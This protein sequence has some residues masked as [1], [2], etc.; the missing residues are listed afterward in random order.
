MCS[1]CMW[2]LSNNINAAAVPELRAPGAV[3]NFNQALAQCDYDLEEWRATKVGVE[4]CSITTSLNRNHP[5]P[6]PDLSGT[7]IT[8]RI[9]NSAG[10]CM[11]LV[12]CWA[13]CC[14][15]APHG[16]PACEA[17]SNAERVS[18][19]SARTGG[20]LRLHPAGQ[21]EVSRLEP[22]AEAAVPAKPPQPGA[23]GRRRRAAPPLLPA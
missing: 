10:F 16:A 21:E 2:D 7:G 5:S 13:W 23:P 11:L 1:D 4:S 19:S 9:H 6:F 14:C 22:G 12:K 15:H 18:G 17:P 8:A 3:R 20:A